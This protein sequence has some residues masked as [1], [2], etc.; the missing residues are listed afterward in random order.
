MLEPSLS[1]E[2][3]RR[4]IPPA[5][6]ASASTTEPLRPD[7]RPERRRGAEVQW[8]AYLGIVIFVLIVTTFSIWIPDLFLT[9]SNWQSIAQTGA[10]TAILAV[11]LLIPLSAGAYDL[12]CA[13]CLGFTSLVCSWLMIQG[14]RLSVPVAIAITLLVGLVVGLLN[15]FLVAFLRLDSFIATLGSTSLLLAGCILIANSEYLGPFPSDFTSLTSGRFLGVP[16]ICLY[17]AALGLLVWY[18]L[19]HTPLGRRIQATGAN[20]EAA[21]LAGLR[22]RRLIFGSLVASAVVASIAG[23]LYASVIGTT[24]QNDGPPY[25]L[26]A[27]TAAFLGA[28]Q[29]KPGT[30]NVGGTVIAVYLLGTGVQG[31]QLIGGQ[32]WIVTAFNGAALLVAVSSAQISERLRGDQA[33]SR[34]LRRFSSRSEH[35]DRLEA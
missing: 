28:T 8:S 30:F 6:S 33:V 4:A 12:S 11:G 23:I 18:V 35:P 17:L 1:T 2:A 32:I 24:N 25:L 29:L 27:F 34:M 19:E 14:P 16:T 21:R 3:S 31:L 26:P 5:D 7:V 15:G 20:A 13:Q 22:T 10:I 9:T